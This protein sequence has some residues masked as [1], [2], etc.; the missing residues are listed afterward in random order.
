MNCIFFNCPIIFSI[1]LFLTLCRHTGNINP[2]N[3]ELNPICHLLALVGAHHILHVSR[4][5]VK[6]IC[7]FVRT[8]I[9][10]SF[11]VP[12]LMLPA[13]RSNDTEAA[14]TTQKVQRA[15]LRRWNL[16]A[17]VTKSLERGTNEFGMN[18][19]D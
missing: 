18:A 13:C 15:C 12:N 3:A 2:L 8:L 7:I 1:F 14:G 9:H 5:R 16:T 11:S 10:F 6:H 4:A 17:T 19:S